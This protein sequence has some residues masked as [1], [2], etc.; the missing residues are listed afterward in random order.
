RCHVQ[1]IGAG[2]TRDGSIEEALERTGVM[3]TTRLSTADVAA[4]A[5]YIGVR[6]HSP[7]PRTSAAPSRAPALLPTLMSMYRSEN[8]ESNVGPVSSAA[9][10]EVSPVKNNPLPAP[11][12]TP[13]P[14][15]N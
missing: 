8:T 10:R 1:R 3:N 2:A 4:F 12:K 5:T 11:I 13:A 7:N 14:T 9:S 6:A 15:R